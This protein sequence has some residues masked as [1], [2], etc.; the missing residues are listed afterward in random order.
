MAPA[1][2]FAAARPPPVC[3]P[4]HRRRHRDHRRRGSGHGRRPKP[5]LCLRDLDRRW[6]GRLAKL[7]GCTAIDHASDL[8]RPCGGHGF[9][10]G[11]ME[12]RGGGPDADGRARGWDR[13]LCDPAADVSSYS[14]LRDCRLSWRRVLGERASHPTGLSGRQRTRRL[15]DDES[16]RAAFDR[17]YFSQSAQSAWSDQQIAGH[18][19]DRGSSQFFSVLSTQC[20]DLHGTRLL[21]RRPLCQQR[22]RTWF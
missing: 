17:L 3:E 19:R 13:W 11:A 9:P 2:G 10:R 5:G 12:H 18:S 7:L 4:T 15:S 20:G 21:P 1:F 8:H 14:R 6:A 16:D 22:H